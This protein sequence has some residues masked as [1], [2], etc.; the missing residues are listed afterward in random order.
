MRILF[1]IHSLSTGGAERVTST[2]ANYWAE[3]GWSV[4]VVTVAGRERDFYML[5]ERIERIALSLDI[6][7]ANSWQAVIN[8]V[9]RV[10]ALRHVLRNVQPDVAVAM[11]AT[12]NATLAIAGWGLPLKTVGSERIY[13]PAISLG[14]AWET[15]RS[16]SY[17]RLNGLVVQT[18]QSAEWLKKNASARRIEVI[19][20]PLRYPLPVQEPRVAPK[21]FLKE[22]GCV[23]ML[24]SVGRLDFQKGFDR[25]LNAF[26]S[27]S[28]A[29]PDWALVILGE[30]PL[31]KSLEAQ[32]RALG[33][34]HRV[35]LPGAVGN[36]A[37]WY[38]AADIYVLTSRFEGFPNTLVEA[39]AY[40][41]P[42]VAVDCQT[43]PREILRHGV[44]GLLVP[45]DDHRALVD[46]LDHLMAD[47]ALR[48]RFAQRAVE[49][50]ERFSVEKI[51]AQWEYLFQECLEE[52]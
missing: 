22:S 10:R 30:G 28:E 6:D 16:W 29:N 33:I 3:K 25:L 26:A 44:D 13:P 1:Y 2:L 41:L 31:R 52:S 42:A 51:A 48:A 46:A 39:L 38:E 15:I 47:S 32:A 37:E 17:P 36:V 50:R 23:R 49:T 27:I 43:G 19:P 24:L 8:N 35:R 21:D 18:Q 4:T 34:E 14:K 45:Q 20:N 12:A 7:S 5:D 9:R 11:M 40:G